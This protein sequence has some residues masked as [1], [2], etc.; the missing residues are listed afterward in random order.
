LEANGLW[1]LLTKRNLALCL[2]LPPSCKG[3]TGFL[4]V[5]FVVAKLARVAKPV[6]ANLEAVVLCFELRDLHPKRALSEQGS[7]IIRTLS[8]NLATSSSA[9]AIL[10]CTGQGQT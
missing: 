6:Q 7:E 5:C 8:R 9:V 1:Y 3:Q 4:A 2:F 10:F